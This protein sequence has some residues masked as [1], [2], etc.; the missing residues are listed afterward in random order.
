MAKVR[1]RTLKKVT[2]GNFRLSADDHAFLTDLQRVRIIAETDANNTHYSNRKTTASKRLNKLVEAGLLKKLEITVPGQGVLG[3]YSFAD[4][5]VAAKYS[6]KMP[7]ISRMRNGHHELIVSRL[8]FAE[9][10]PDTFKIEADFCDADMEVFRRAGESVSEMAT[11]DAMYLSVHGEPVV[12]EADSGQYNSTQ[13]K[14]KVSA[15]A[16]FKQV[17]GQPR[18]RKS[19]V[20]N[21]CDAVVHRF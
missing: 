15:W 10:R 14:N 9:G 13:I 1:T 3:A 5:H 6:S 8:F 16:G 18:V 4:E 11:P 20:E 19:A 2:G 17:W 21:Y 12:I 7:N